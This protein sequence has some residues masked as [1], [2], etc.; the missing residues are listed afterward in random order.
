MQ[1]LVEDLIDTDH[2]KLMRIFS[3]KRVSNIK[4]I[5][6]VENAIKDN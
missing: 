3:V 1:E 6:I 4:N 5:K 2:Y